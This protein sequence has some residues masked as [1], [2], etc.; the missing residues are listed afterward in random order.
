[1]DIERRIIGEKQ[2]YIFESHHF[3]LLP[4][5]YAKRNYEGSEMNLFTFDYHTDIIEPFLRY[6]YDKKRDLIDEAKQSKLLNEVNYHNDKSIENAI[7]KLRN[8]EHIK[9]AIGC[10]IIN[11]ALIISHSG[12]ETPKSNEERVRLDRLWTKESI[13]Q[14]ITNTYKI[15]S[16]EQRTYPE[17]DIYMPQFDCESAEEILDDAF[18]SN[19]LAVL[20]RMSNLI[21]SDGVMLT[22]YVLDIDLDYFITPKAIKPKSHHIFTNLVRNAELITIAKESVCVDMCSNG[23]ANS[24]YLLNEMIRLLEVSLC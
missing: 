13:M 23:T 16:M 24:D 17:S 6:S 10:E 20:K 22:P 2:V 3:A 19:Q 7:G 21:S 14:I 5:A 4:W 1:M 12:D 15:T 11:H 18:L 9:T 8:D